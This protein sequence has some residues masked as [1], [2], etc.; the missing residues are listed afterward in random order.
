MRANGILPNYPIGNTLIC[1]ITLEIIYV[2]GTSSI[3]PSKQIVSPCNLP[4]PGLGVNGIPLAIG[5][6]KKARKTLWDGA[7]KMVAEYEKNPKVDWVRF[8]KVQYQTN[9]TDPTFTTN[10]IRKFVSSE[11][12]S[13]DIPSD[14]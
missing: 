10:F 4:P 5:E 11:S 8:H 9:K 2:G 14:F 13:T 1:D 7:K 6:I 12:G 3:E